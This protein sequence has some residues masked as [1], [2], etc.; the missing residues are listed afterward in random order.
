M[1]F[2]FQCPNCE[3]NYQIKEKLSGKQAKCKKCGELMTL[4]PAEPEVSE[5]GSTMYRHQEREREFEPAA[6]DGELIEEV[7]DHLEKHLGE[8]HGV[9]HEIV[10]DLVHVDV[11]YHGPTEEFPWQ[12]LVTSGMSQLPMTV[13][14]DAEVS[15]YA[16]LV[17]CLPPDWPLTD[18]AFQD[19]YFYWPLG[20]M[21]FLAR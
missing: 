16:E 2:P 6:G 9:F 5:G 10:S 8:C 12:T 1:P 21:K 14:P 7:S 13:P 11:H 18:E 20:W 3:A 17:T 15:D 4:T 19:E